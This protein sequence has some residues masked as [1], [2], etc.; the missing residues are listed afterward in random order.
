M[1]RRREVGNDG[2]VVEGDLTFIECLLCASSELV[3][4]IPCLHYLMQLYDIGNYLHLMSEETKT[5]RG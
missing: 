4:Y 3:L 5:Q 2:K 1:G